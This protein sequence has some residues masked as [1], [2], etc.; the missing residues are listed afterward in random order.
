MKFTK[1]KIT[2]DLLMIREEV[3]TSKRTDKITAAQDYCLK[4]FYKENKTSKEVL[5]SKNNKRPRREAQSQ[6]MVWAS[7]LEILP[8]IYSRLFHVQYKRQ[9]TK[10]GLAHRINSFSFSSYTGCSNH[11]SSGTQPPS[12]N[13]YCHCQVIL[14]LCLITFKIRQTETL[15]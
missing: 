11:T 7:Q 6:A 10:I 2:L 15:L 4:L 14:T 1:Y 9:H 13:M 5:D 12:L 8:Y 3:I